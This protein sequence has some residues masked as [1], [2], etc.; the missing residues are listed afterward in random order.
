MLAWQASDP[1][2]AV[3]NRTAQLDVKV[4]A[5]LWPKHRCK[6]FIGK[7]TW[8]D[9]DRGSSDASWMWISRVPCSS[10][11]AASDSGQPASVSHQSVS[12]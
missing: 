5:M 8:L 9:N 4:Q 10:T 11:M 7:H 6:S 3:C 12:P 2:D 1:T